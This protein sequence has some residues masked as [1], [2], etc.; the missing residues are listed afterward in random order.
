MYMLRWFKAFGRRCWK[1]AAWLMGFV[2]L[3]ACRFCYYASAVAAVPT[4]IFA[5]WRIWECLVRNEFTERDLLIWG[6]SGGMIALCCLCDSYSSYSLRDYCDKLRCD[7]FV[8]MDVRGDVYDFTSDSKKVI[9]K[10][11]RNTN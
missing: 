5:V 10:P 11:Y 9:R 2:L 3:V 6:V 8:P 1:F 7:I 4:T